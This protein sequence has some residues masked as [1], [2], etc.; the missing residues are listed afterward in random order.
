MELVR[1]LFFLCLASFRARLMVDGE[2][3]CDDIVDDSRIDVVG[4]TN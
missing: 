1:P 2:G 4:T 3:R